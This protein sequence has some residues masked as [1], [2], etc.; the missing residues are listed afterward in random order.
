MGMSF[1][2]VAN[3]SIVLSTI[4]VSNQTGFMFL[5]MM[6]VNDGEYCGI[7][8][9]KDFFNCCN[10]MAFGK[11]APMTVN[12]EMSMMGLISYGKRF[13]E[14]ENVIAIHLAADPESDV[15]ISYG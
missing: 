11:C 8:P 9:G 6:G 14:M 7:I 4:D 3:G 1:Q 15:H 5:R 10:G 2:V 12:V 13:R